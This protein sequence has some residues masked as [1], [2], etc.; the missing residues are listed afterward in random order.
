MYGV[1]DGG[2]LLAG[3]DTVLFEYSGGNPLYIGKAR[4][5]TDTSASAWQIQR[6]TYS[7]NDMTAREWANAT[8]KYDK[9]WDDRAS[10]SYS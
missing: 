10:Y 7:G 8:A 1:L 9:V 2:Q 5:G 3:Q 4:P 6:T